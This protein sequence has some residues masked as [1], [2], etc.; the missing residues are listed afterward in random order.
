MSRAAGRAGGPPRCA[1]SRRDQ[2]SQTGPLTPES[3]DDSFERAAAFYAEHFGDYPTSRFYCGS[4]LLDPHAAN[5]GIRGRQYSVTSGPLG[6]LA[7]GLIEDPAMPAGASLPHQF[8]RRTWPA[9]VGVVSGP[10]F[11][12][13]VAY[14]LPTALAVAATDHA[15]AVKVASLLR[16]EPLRAYVSDDITGV[17]VG[18]AVKNVLAIAAGA[19]DGLGFGHNARAALITRG[20]AETGLEQ[21][22]AHAGGRRI[23]ITHEAAHRAGRGRQMQRKGSR[24][25]RA[26]IQFGSINVGPAEIHGPDVDARRRN[27]DAVATR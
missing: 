12:E 3:V 24:G 9:A 22:H 21:R 13:E 11:A 25:A 5:N 27:G 4:W 14:G 18:G 23:A 26:Q 19:S 17:E 1:A 20:L 10:S 6:W 2:F 15:L 7:K 8:I 16:A